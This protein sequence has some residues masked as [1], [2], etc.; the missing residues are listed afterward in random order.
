MQTHITVYEHDGWGGSRERFAS[1]WRGAP[2][3][4][5][6]ENPHTTPRAL[7][8]KAREEFPA[9]P[10]GVA[11]ADVRQLAERILACHRCRVYVIRQQ[12]VP[13]SLLAWFRLHLIVRTFYD[14]DDTREFEF[15][16]YAI[17]WAL[18]MTDREALLA[19]P[20]T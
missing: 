19:L 9:L 7:T 17:S 3:L 1:D 16:G 18:R 11:A 5:V 4:G 10:E 15:A 12:G 13:P 14:T 2:V 20:L 8:E 6:Y